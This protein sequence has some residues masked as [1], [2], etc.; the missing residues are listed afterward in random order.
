MYIFR[1]V[2]PFS[3][4]PLRFQLDTT[5]VGRCSS[6]KY[7]EY[8]KV[9]LSLKFKPR[10]FVLM[11]LTSPNGTTSRLLYKRQF[12]AITRR[13]YYNNL[14]VSSLHYW[15]EDPNG[16]WSFLFQ[17]SRPWFRTNGKDINAMFD[18]SK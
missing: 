10:A 2:I 14:V 1:M 9:K 4:S 11:D 5:R 7:I 16:N 18:S 8:A 13:M 15:G 6:I 17:N 12:D 3:G